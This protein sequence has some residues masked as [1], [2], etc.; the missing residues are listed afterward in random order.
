MINGHWSDAVMASTAAPTYFPS[1]DGSF[2]DG[3]VGSYNNPC[4]LAA[5]EI[6]FVLSWKL[7]ETTLHQHSERDA[8]PAR[9]KKAQWIVSS[10]FNIS[11]LC[12]M[13]SHILR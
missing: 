6:Q 12:W 7:E 1:L 11:A 8:N 4:Y 5:Y 9:S 2:I 10:P 3:G 13:P